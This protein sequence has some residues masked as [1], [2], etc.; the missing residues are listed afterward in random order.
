M[1]LTSHLA[2]EQAGDWGSGAA[3]VAQAAADILL[4]SLGQADFC[5]FPMNT[6]EVECG[7]KEVDFSWACFKNCLDNP[8]I[9]CTLGPL[10]L[11]LL[12]HNQGQAG[13]LDTCPGA[14]LIIVFS[15]YPSA[16]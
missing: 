16:K 5:Y 4:A 9:C 11:L 15:F 7:P 10:F 2:T 14:H 1:A 6:P 13:Q 12:I 3:E 8:L